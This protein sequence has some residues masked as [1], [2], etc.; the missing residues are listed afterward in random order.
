[1]KI[2][3]QVN[4]DQYGNESKAKSGRLYSI[5][6][7]AELLIEKYKLSLSQGIKPKILIVTTGT[8]LALFDYLR[9][10]KMPCTALKVAISRIGGADILKY[11]EED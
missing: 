6:E 10:K 3:W 1:M 4:I 7:T 9:D 11:K 8:G 2:T 5:E